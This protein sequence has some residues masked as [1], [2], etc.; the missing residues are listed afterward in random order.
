MCY[1]HGIMNWHDSTSPK[2]PKWDTDM[3][4]NEQLQASVLVTG[5]KK[6]AHQLSLMG[7]R[8]KIV[9]RTK[10]GK[11]FDIL[12][13]RPRPHGTSDQMSP[14]WEQT[15]T[16]TWEAYDALR[17]KHAHISHKGG[18]ILPCI[19]FHLF[20]SMTDWQELCITNIGMDIDT[21]Q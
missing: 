19:P 4:I 6:C 5:Q 20:I 17:N 18:F 2:G 14:P 1:T 16:S 7:T 10:S 8:A 13:R 21:H 11:M 9:W 12:H 3:K 15:W